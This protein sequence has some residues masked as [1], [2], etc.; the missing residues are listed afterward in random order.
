MFSRSEMKTYTQDSIKKLK[1]HVYV[2][3]RQHEELRKAKEDLQDGSVIMLCD[4]SENF[5]CRI[6][7]E[8]MAAHWRS[9]CSGQ[10]TIYTSIVYFWSGH[11]VIH[12]A[13]AI[14]SD[15]LHHTHRETAVFNE[16]I[17]DDISKITKVEEVMVWS[18]GAAAQFKCRH[19]MGHML[20]SNYNITSWN[21][22]E[23]YHGKGPHDGIGKLMTKY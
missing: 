7:R 23:S 12:K 15:T 9:D 20:K 2:N 16:K 3:Q 19:T 10:V 1:Q 18:D 8:V 5:Q 6:Q 4:F 11:K 22:F 14:I 13:Y 17:L 21:F